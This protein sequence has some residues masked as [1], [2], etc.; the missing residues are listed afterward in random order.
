MA[1]SLY[2]DFQCLGN[3]KKNGIFNLTSDMLASV[4]VAQPPGSS[5]HNQGLCF[6]R[7]N[8]IDGYISRDYG[9]K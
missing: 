7:Q 8:R 2:T 3:Y 1:C 6:K 9:D 4:N 5:D